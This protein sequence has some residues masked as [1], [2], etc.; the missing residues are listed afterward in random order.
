MNAVKL[1]G[2]GKKTTFMYPKGKIPLLPV[3]FYNY[4]LSLCMAIAAGRSDLLR[5]SEQQLSRI[6]RCVEGGQCRSSRSL[7]C[8]A[9]F[10]A[11]G[12]PEQSPAQCID[13]ELAS[14]CSSR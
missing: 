9:F 2:G 1:K 10:F 14:G 7:A 13:P 12:S 11:R 5:R 4:E 8:A 6:S 3:I